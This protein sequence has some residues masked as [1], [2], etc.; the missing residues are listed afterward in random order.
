M[1]AYDAYLWAKKQYKD[2]EAD[3]EYKVAKNGNSGFYFHVG[4]VKSPV[5]T[6]IEVQIYDSFSRGKDAKLND[7]DSGRHHSRHP[8]DQEHRQGPRRME[9]HAGHVQGRQGG[10]EAQRRSG[11]R[12]A[13]GSR[14]DQD[15]AIDRSGR[16]SGSRV[17][18]LVSQHKDERAAVVFSIY[19]F[20]FAQFCRAQQTMRIG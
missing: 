16:V 13:V 7:H 2:F 17:A 4:D 18:A 20:A 14:Q 10:R 11:Q 1:A 5:A 6:G 15:E 8:A 19:R 9:P 12:C 3:F